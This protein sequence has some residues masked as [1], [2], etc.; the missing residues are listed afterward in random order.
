[1]F[2]H[3]LNSS[4]QNWKAPASTSLRLIHSLLS[5]ALK[6]LNE[7]RDEQKNWWLRRLMEFFVVKAFNHEFYKVVWKLFYLLGS[8]ELIIYSDN[9]RMLVCHSW[10]LPFLFRTSSFCSQVIL[11]PFDKHLSSP[12]I[13]SSIRIPASPSPSETIDSYRISEFSPMEN[14]LTTWKLGVCL[15]V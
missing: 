8:G 1:M 5:A 2:H 7:Q 9:L 10:P 6:Y 11:N 4:L 12:L 14:E 15:M 13:P 3:R